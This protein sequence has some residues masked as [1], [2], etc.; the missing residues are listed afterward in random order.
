MM[1]RETQR[2]IERLREQVQL[3]AGERGSADKSKTAI[4][5]GELRALA[6]L[7]MKSSQISAAPTQA[8]FNRL[9]ADVAA[10]YAAFVLISN[11][12]GNAKIPKL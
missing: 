11:L 1:D 8:D 12:L 6:S 5:R 2:E 3:L 9:Q 10:I 4:R 7:E